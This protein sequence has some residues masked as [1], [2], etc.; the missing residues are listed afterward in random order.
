MSIDWFLE[1]SRNPDLKKE[2]IH[3]LKAE[4]ERHNKLYYEQDKP[5]I[6][7]AEY[8]K[9]R[10][11][12]EKFIENDS[13]NAQLDLLSSLNT[14]GYK[15]SEKFKKVK[16]SRPMLS[17]SNAFS[18]EDLYSFDEKI[19]NFLNF[20]TDSEIEYIAE[21]KI[22]GL[23]FSAEYRNG[24][25][26][27][28]STRGD[29]EYGEDITLNVKTIASLPQK[30]LLNDDFEIRGEIY[31]DKNDFSRLNESRKLN[32]EDLFANPRNAAAGSLR[33]LDFEVTRSR[34]LK[35]FIWGG[36]INGVSS[37]SELIEKFASIGFTT[38]LRITTAKNI[39]DLMHYYNSLFADR[40]AL[41]YDIDGVVYKVNNFGLQ[42]R[43]GELIRTPRWAI[44]HKFPAEKAITKILSIDVQVGRTGALTPVANL[45]PV[46]V[47]GVIVSRA[48]LHNQDELERKDT[49]VGDTVL[50]QRAGDVIPQILEVD[51]SKRQN[52]SE[53]FILPDNCPICG[54]HALKE[55]GEAIKRCTGGLKCEA[56]IIE[57]MKHFVSRDAF[58]IEGLGERQ[59]EEFFTKKII[60]TPVDIFSLNQHESEIKKWEGF[61]EKSVYKLLE[62]IEKSKEVKLEKFIY[63]LGIRLVGEATSKL[64]SREYKSLIKI[65]EVCKSENALDDLLRIDGIGEKVAKHIIEFFNDSF[66]TEMLNS[67]GEILKISEYKVEEIKSHI[68]GKTIVFTGT[69][70]NMGR[71]EA[72]ATAEKLGARVASSISAKTDFL[73]AGAESGS[74]LK[75][76]QELGV[77]TLTEEE[78]LNIIERINSF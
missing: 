25:L 72:K 52:G 29:G 3:N 14:V 65:Q 62:S 70:I 36:F 30:V 66:N 58:N 51:L 69:L 33:Q 67:L 47:G 8:D 17:L 2:E 24:Q 50:I 63:A 59:I 27:V 44:A 19:R 61:G 78:W 56:Q 53:K 74:K 4:I 23:S 7:D 28:A 32:G 68:S 40:S 16:H 12:V 41:E 46:G 18:E 45:E 43:L 1:M 34:N 20:S 10:M 22:D 49:R 38:N 15:P 13:K 37:Q 35:Y 31:M 71:N 48:T 54:S 21:P 11:Q 64:I 60:S 42:S 73:V 76:A 9:L 5:E 39:S 57:R 6:S 77:K 75:K 26:F 55:E